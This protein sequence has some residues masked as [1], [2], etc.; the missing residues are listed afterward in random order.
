M[1][2]R[3]DPCEWRFLCLPRKK[4]VMRQVTEENDIL[5]AV[6][7][8]LELGVAK[9]GAHHFFLVL[10]QCLLTV[11][12]VLC[13]HLL[14]VSRSKQ[15]LMP[16]AAHPAEPAAAH[17]AEPAAAPAAEH[18]AAPAAEHGAAPAADPRVAAP[19]AA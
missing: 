12:L 15:R 11:L 4:G 13:I 2:R 7:L 6:R 10:L 19:R 5:E 3:D 9:Q 17:P 14:D 8:G 18:G 16:Q 1:I